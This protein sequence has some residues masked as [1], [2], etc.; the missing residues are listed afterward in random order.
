MY[1]IHQGSVGR[2]Q[3]S[4][5]EFNQIFQ[6]GP[7]S[8][9]VEDLLQAIGL[10]NELSQYETVNNSQQ[11]INQQQGLTTARIHEFQQFPADESLVGNRCGVCLDDIEAGRRMMRLDCDGQHVLCQD[12][13]EG[14]FADH[15]TCPNCRHIFT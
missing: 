6:N 8:V 2:H 3:R 11:Q 15:N 5:Q 14:W 1:Y 13:V 10:L 7:G 9:N 4:L 12:C